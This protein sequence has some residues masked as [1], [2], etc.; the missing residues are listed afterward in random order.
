MNTTHRSRGTTPQLRRGAAIAAFL[1]IVFAVALLARTAS[2][3]GSGEEPARFF[4]LWR[5]RHALLAL[6]LAWSALA[7]AA[8][9]LSSRSFARWIAASLSIGITFGAAEALSLFG[10]LRFPSRERANAVNELGARAQPHLDVRGETGEDLALA[11]GLDTPKVPFHY[12][13]DR[14]GFRNHLDR[15]DAAIYCLGDSFL[16]AGLLPA[17]ELVAR[18]LEQR[19]QRS[20]MNLALVGLAPQDEAALL[21]ESGV[22]LAGRLVLHFLF[23][24]NDLRDSARFRTSGRAQAAADAAPSWRERSLA[25]RFIVW[26]Q[27]ITQ[28]AAQSASARVEGTIGLQ[29][30]L[31]FW[32]SNSY[33]GFEGELEPIMTCLEGVRA[34]VEAAGGRYAVVLIPQKIRVL[35]PYCSAPAGTPVARWEEQLSPLPAHLAAW[36][37]RTGT[38]TLDLTDALRAATARG[39]VPWFPSD[40]HWNAIGHS[41]AAEAIAGWAPVVAWSASTELR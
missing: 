9:A 7:S 20:T 25:N 6:A 5:T 30:Y 1:G 21:R 41:V 19:L 29:R 31:F 15:A 12:R 24:G 16:V 13:T 10:V 36:S 34:E 23:E 37:A 28:P 26:L 18:R 11:W 3:E 8:L 14:R 32:L 40:T 17:E 4:G 2:S 22:A 35:G 39:E 27:E 38:P 33:R